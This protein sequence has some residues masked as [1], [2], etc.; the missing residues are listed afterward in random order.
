MYQL[1]PPAAATSSASSVPRLNVRHA[2][3]DDDEEEEEEEAA[4]AAASQR[5]GLRAVAA[6]PVRTRSA[7]QQAE[8][9][10]VCSSPEPSP[11]LGGMRGARRALTMGLFLHAVGSVS[12]TE[13]AADRVRARRSEAVPPPG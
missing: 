9:P 7:G 10:R 8:S 12:P 2:D 3:D 4:R 6:P 1:Y 13:S 5:H 11:R